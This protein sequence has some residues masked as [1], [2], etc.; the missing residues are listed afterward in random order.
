MVSQNSKSF[1]AERIGPSFC[2]A[3]DCVGVGIH[4]GQLQVAWSQDRNFFVVGNAGASTISSLAH[5]QVL[6]LH[7]MSGKAPYSAERKCLYRNE[8]ELYDEGIFCRLLHGERLDAL[9]LSVA[10]LELLHNNAVSCV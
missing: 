8:I 7:G 6:H 2:F 4:D 9:P 5:D 10:T 1:S 3:T